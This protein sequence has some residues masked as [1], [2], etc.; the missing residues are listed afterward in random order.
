[1]KTY[2]YLVLVIVFCS[3]EEI[4]EVEDISQE[5]VTVLAPTDQSVINTTQVRFSWQPVAFAELYQLQV[6]T[7]N[8]LEA[9]QITEDTLI[10]STNFD[11]ILQI[12]NYEWRIRGVNSAY[13]TRYKIQAFTIED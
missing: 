3:C 13:E 9:T 6:A 12:G 5:Q 11:K 10:T 7:P 2:F 4:V 1:M 8:F